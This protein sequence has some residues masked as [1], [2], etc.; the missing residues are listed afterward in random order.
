VV[1]VGDDLSLLVR[2]RQ[3]CNLRRERDASQLTQV[4]LVDHSVAQVNYSLYAGLC[5]LYFVRS[6]SF[7][8]KSN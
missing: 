4:S 6:T 5:L 2:V 8:S 1:D 3:H 7:A